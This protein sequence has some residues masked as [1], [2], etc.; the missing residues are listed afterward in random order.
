MAIFLILSHSEQPLLPLA[1]GNQKLFED[2]ME[3]GLLSIQFTLKSIL[4]REKLTKSEI[5]Y[6]KTFCEENIKKKIKALYQDIM[7]MSNL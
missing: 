1:H 2:L 6:S 3:K 4:K 7:I 5:N